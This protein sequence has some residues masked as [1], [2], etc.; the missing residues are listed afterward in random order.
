MKII[1]LV[2]GVAS[3]KSLVARQ[4]ET[5]GAGVLEADAGTYEVLKQPEVEAAIET[6][7]GRRVFGADGRVDRAQLAKIVF[8]PSPDGPA[9]RKYLEQLLHP[10]IGELVRRKAERLAEQGCPAAVLDAPLLIEA[11]WDGWCD[12]IVF[13][14]CPRELRE[15]RAASR[16]WTQEE[17]AA[18][19]DAQESLD[20][21]R[22]RADVIID[23]A[24][25]PASTQARIERIWHSLIG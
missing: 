16:G 7:W 13:V 22:S 20:R 10:R 25:S 2:G 15:S 3:G 24:G 11:G 21:K 19:E 1:G 14:D 5:L 9:E 18:R 4:F 8:A 17:F 6:R 12:K 23:N